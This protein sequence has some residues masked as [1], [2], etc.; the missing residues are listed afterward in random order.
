MHY[1][2]NVPAV[3][4]TAFL[5][6]VGAA[7]GLEAY[8]VIVAGA[9][10]SLIKDLAFMVAGALIRSAFPTIETVRKPGE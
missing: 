7:V 6:L 5:V 3:A 8:T 4:S 2:T 10:I 9:P 1:I